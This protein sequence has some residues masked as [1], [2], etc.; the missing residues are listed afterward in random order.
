MSG[1]SRQGDMQTDKIGLLQE[2]TLLNPGGVEFRLE[3]GIQTLAIVVQNTH[4]KTFGAACHGLPDAAHAA[5]PECFAMDITSRHEQQG[6]V[7]PF[8]GP[9]VTV[10]LRNTPGETT[11]QRPGEISR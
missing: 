4:V 7:A 8:A 10:A 6:P 9:D 2:C 3:G 5:N 1:R 11:E